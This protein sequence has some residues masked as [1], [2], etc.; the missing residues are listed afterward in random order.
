MPEN[1]DRKKKMFKNG[2]FGLC[3]SM[4]GGRAVGGMMTAASNL[5]HEQ[6]TAV[7]VSLRKCE[8]ARVLWAGWLVGFWWAG[9]LVGRLGGLLVRELGWLVVSLVGWL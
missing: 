8:D 7:C 4:E 6:P 2:N 1:V 5:Y 3:E 9:L